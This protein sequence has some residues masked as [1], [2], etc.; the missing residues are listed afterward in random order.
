[1]LKCTFELGKTLE[2]IQIYAFKML[3]RIFF[4]VKT[5]NSTDVFI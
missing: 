2:E 5:F 1:M 3:Q 4:I